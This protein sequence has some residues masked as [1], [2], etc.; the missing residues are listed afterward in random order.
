MSAPST[1]KLEK[2][3]AEL[4]KEREESALAKERMKEYR[5]ESEQ[6]TDLKRAAR[7]IRDQAKAEKE[8]IEGEFKEDLEYQ[9]AVEAERTHREKVRELTHELKELLQAFP[10]KDDI[11]SFEFN[12]LGE[13]QQIQLEKML[14]MYINGKEQR[15]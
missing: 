10:M 14:K 5:I 6:L 13:R 7:D 1:M 11:A 4:V 3:V 15:D 9:D 2:L 8:R 12:I